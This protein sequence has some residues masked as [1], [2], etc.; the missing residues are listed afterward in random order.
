MLST[1]NACQ[2]P[3]D[4]VKECMPAGVASGW[5]NTF[6]LHMGALEKLRDE[7]E[8]IYMGTASD[9][10]EVQDAKAAVDGF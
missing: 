8:S 10:S 1:Q 4:A 7:F 3:D 5:K 6:S 2:D 9:A